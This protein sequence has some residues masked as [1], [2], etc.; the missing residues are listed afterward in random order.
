[1]RIIEECGEVLQ[2]VSKGERFG[3]GNVHPDRPGI[4]N[5]EAL[6]MEI[7]DLNVAFDDFKKGGHADGS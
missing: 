4:T 5:R 2:A 1:M 7:Y 6:E 3:W